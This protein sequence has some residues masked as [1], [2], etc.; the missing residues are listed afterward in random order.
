MLEHTLMV[1]MPDI[2]PDTEVCG[3]GDSVAEAAP[4]ID[5][6]VTEKMYEAL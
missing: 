4:D 1:G 2:D 5:A 6:C 3:D